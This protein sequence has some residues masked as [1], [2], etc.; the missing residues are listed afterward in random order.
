MILSMSVSGIAEHVTSLDREGGM[1]LDNGMVVRLAGLEFPEESLRLFS[2]LLAGKEVHVEMDSLAVPES[3][4]VPVYL[5]VNTSEIELPFPQGLIPHESKVM[6]NELFLRL[7]AA[8]VAA[9]PA[10][11]REDSF[12]M[13]ESEARSKG[14]GIWSYEENLNAAA[15]ET[16]SS[17][18][19]L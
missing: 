15:A 8:R 19:F 16:E 7:G 14:K 5:Y 6:V 1:S 13:L 17:S 18:P 3:Q 12:R 9:A 2:V 4:P 11:D 10:F